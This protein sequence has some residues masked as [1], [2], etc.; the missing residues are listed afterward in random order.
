MSADNG[1]YILVTNR[2]RGKREYRVAHAQCIE[3][4]TDTRDYPPDRGA[5]VNGMCMMEV[6]GDATVLTDRRITEGYAMRMLEEITKDG[7]ICEYGIKWLEY[8]TLRFPKKS[9]QDHRSGL[10][11]AGWEPRY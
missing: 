9:R 2:G 6:F 11:S 4:L 7:G 8:P 1:V 5:L 10:V 3:N